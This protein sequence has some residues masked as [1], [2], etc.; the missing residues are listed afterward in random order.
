LLAISVTLGHPFTRCRVKVVITPKLAHH[1]L[2]TSV[3][4]ELFGISVCELTEGESPTIISS[5]LALF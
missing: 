1:F 3:D 2:L 5:L 4:T